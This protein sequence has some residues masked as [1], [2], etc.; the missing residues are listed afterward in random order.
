MISGLPEEDSVNFAF[1]L[2]NSRFVQIEFSPLEGN[3][4][5]SQFVLASVRF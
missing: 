5:L 3:N 1:D 4:Q 2:G